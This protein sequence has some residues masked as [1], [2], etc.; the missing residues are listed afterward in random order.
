MK[1]KI[2]INNIC[3]LAVS[4]IYSKQ[5]KYKGTPFKKIRENKKLIRLIS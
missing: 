1:N 3:H 5:Q 4:H 2:A